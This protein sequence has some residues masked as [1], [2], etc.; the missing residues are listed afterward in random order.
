[1]A[2]LH[3]NQPVPSPGPSTA[4]P[5]S[6]NT[7]NGVLFRSATR[8]VAA[9]NSDE[10]F[11]PNCKGVRLFLVNDGAGGGTVALQ[12]QVRDPNTD[13]WVNLTGAA[14]AATGATAGTILTVYPGLT[15]I[16]DAAG[17]IN[18]HLG[19]AWRL[20]ATVAVATVTFSVGADYL[21]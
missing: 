8:V 5:S 15:G 9:Y 16:A 1:M 6:T 19:P 14:L 10:V 18:Q 21:L 12:L 11:N 13:A 2:D 7:P 3:T 4:T 20:V 17:N